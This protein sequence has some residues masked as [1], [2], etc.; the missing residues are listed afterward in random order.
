MK[1]FFVALALLV[2]AAVSTATAGPIMFVHDS[3]GNLGRVDVATG[4]TSLIGNM[5]AVMTDIAFDP[6]GNLYGIT[7]TG[8]Y[9]INA[10][11]GASAFIGGLGLNGANA[12]VFSSTGTLY[13]AANNNGNLYTVNTGTGAASFAQSTG[14]A[15]G[16]DLAF[17]GGN[18]YLASTTNS[19]VR[20][21]LGGPSTLVG[22]FGVGS[23]FG[24][25]T[26]DNGTMYGVAGTTVYTID[27]TTGAATNGVSFAGQGLGLAFG[28]SFYTE[29]GA[30]DPVPEPGTMLLVGGGLAAMLRKRR[31]QR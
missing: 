29:A 5:G 7:F 6:T 10:L 27:T 4:T 13:A 1:R 25:A 28:Q 20:I 16:G 14:F 19:L 8:L 30:P 21:T 31:R 12:L 9:S 2:T 11:T 22:A 24:L 23:V 15:S 18:L 26:G 17:N 3:S